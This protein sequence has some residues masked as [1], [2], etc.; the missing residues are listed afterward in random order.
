MADPTDYTVAD[1]IPDGQSYFARWEAAAATFRDGQPTARLARPYGDHPREAYDLFLP[2]STPRGLVVFIHGGFW[3]ITHR[4][5]WSH[6][7]AGPVAAGWACA[8]PSYPLCP[9]VRITGITRS[10]ARAL[11]AM[12]AEIAGPILLAGHSAGGHLAL[13]MLCP[14]AGLPDAV[15]G[16]LRAVLAISPLTD[17][18]P[19][20][21]MP[22]NA[23]L[24]ID[25]AEARA[26]SPIYHPAPDLPVLV[27]VGAEERPAFLD[28]ALWLPDHWPETQ[29][30]IAADRHHF[31]VIEGL[32]RPDSPMLQRFLRHGR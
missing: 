16:R 2:S 19:L 8:L 31:D 4:A 10:I 18:A 12:A 30:V 13:R 21:E 6:L 7:A 11:P 28:Q 3:R 9:E 20:M 29:V 24:R 15:A 14:D 22:M 32:Q 17:L 27:E 26:E 1:F 25:A 23:D 5:L